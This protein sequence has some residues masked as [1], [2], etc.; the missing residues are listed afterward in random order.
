MFHRTQLAAE[1]SSLRENVE[2]KLYVILC[3]VQ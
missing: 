3:I 1:L 2:K